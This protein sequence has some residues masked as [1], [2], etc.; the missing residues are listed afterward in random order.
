M[1]KGIE[2]LIESIIKIAIDELKFDKNDL[3]NI[4]NIYI[5]NIKFQEK[6]YKPSI[7]LPENMTLK[8]FCKNKIYEQKYYDKITSY[9]KLIEL[10]KTDES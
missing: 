9:P 4:K 10:M 8:E 6:N 7:T 3:E 2:I 5:G 1:L